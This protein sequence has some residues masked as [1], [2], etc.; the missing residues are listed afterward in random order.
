MTTYEVSLAGGVFYT[1]APT[2]YYK[3]SVNGS[4]TGETCWRLLSPY[5][6]GGGSAWVFGVCGSSIPGRLYG[7]DVYYTD[8][9][10]PALS[11]K[12]CVKYSSGDGSASAPYTIKET[13]SGC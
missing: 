3:N 8:G 1:N 2:W 10:R 5:G 9:V 11:L 13:T 7:N 6:W 4:S 12:S